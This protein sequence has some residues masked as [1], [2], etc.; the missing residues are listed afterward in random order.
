[1]DDDDDSTGGGGGGTLV[2]QPRASDPHAARQSGGLPSFEG[3]ASADDRP[4]FDPATL[5]KPGA[6]GATGTA[7]T[8]QM[9]MVS[10]PYAGREEFTPSA[11]APIG[12]IPPS[13]LARGLPGLHRP[14]PPP[15][16]PLAPQPTHT[17][18]VGP[19]MPRAPSAPDHHGFEQ[20]PQ[21]Q[22]E[23]P[24]AW[25]PA[26]EEA[27]YEAGAPPPKRKSLLPLALGVAIGLMLVMIFAMIIIL[28]RDPTPPETA[29][30]ATATQAQPS[31]PAPT[32]IETVAPPV[33]SAEPPKPAGVDGEAVAALEKLRDSIDH[34]VKTRI[35]VLPGTSPAIPA[36]LAWLKKGPYTPMKRDFAKPFFACTEFKL[37]APMRFMLQWQVDKPSV[38]G[39]GMAWIDADGDGVAEKAY[40]F[41]AKLEGRDKVSFGPIEASDATRKLQRAF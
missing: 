5:L 16:A 40:A 28:V 2:I 20:A 30:T 1:V 39:T 32:A 37:E 27:P 4:S 3:E 6:Q 14:N 38:E 9:P 34:C 31:Q 35:H 13:E 10:G 26:V 18:L 12:L 17:E 33:T 19:Y 36:S 15:E 8:L 24:P 23:P 21:L 25:G 11:T 41:K 7:G 22:P 29:S